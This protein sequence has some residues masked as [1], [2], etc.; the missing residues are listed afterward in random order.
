MS[1]IQP[2][3]LSNKELAHYCAVFI[4]DQDGL[5]KHW[6]TELLRRFVALVPTDEHKFIDPQQLDLFK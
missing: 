5:P 2:R 3:T 6:Q 4:E 1:G